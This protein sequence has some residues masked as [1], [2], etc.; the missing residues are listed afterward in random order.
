MAPL[1]SVALWAIG[2]LLLALPSL[3]A[4]DDETWYKIQNND[5]STSWLLEGRKPS[6]YTTN[7]GSCL[8]NSLIDVTRFDA[9]FYHDNMTVIFDIG[10][11]TQLNNESL[12]S[13]FSRLPHHDQS[14][15]VVQVY[16][17]VYAYGESRFELPFDP[18]KANIA[19][20]VLLPLSRSSHTY[21]LCQH[22]PSL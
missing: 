17:G 16:I 18:C 20:Y 6:L 5:G 1:F 9:A 10:G 21:L 8:E 13:R 4:A 11:N 3:S 14:L 15:I 2:Y 12:M 22:V 7:F 19:R